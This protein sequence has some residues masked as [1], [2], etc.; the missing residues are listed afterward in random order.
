MQIP[1]KIF[2]PNGCFSLILNMTHGTLVVKRQND[3]IY[4]FSRLT[5]FIYVRVW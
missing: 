5:L 2:S 3:T 1:A 4:N